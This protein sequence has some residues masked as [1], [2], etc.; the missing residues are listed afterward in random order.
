LCG[1]IADVPTRPGL[2]ELLD[3]LDAHGVPAVVV[4]SGLA[5]L[6]RAHLRE[7]VRRFA[8]LYA[9]EADLT[10]PHLRVIAP[11][12]EGD[13]IVSK[14]AIL[15]RHPAA[16]Q[17]VVGDSITDRRMAAIAQLVFARDRLVGHCQEAGITF[18]E[19]ADFHDIRAEL[20]RRWGAPPAR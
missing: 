6:C 19:W 12:A 20:A 7:R 5:A 14:P 9:M 1:S 15:R 16:E 18:V 10:G 8:G 17:V 11:D 3:F 2:D 13:E 4:S